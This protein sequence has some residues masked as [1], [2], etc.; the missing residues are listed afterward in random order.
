MQVKEWLYEEFPEFTEEVENVTVL[1]SPGDETGIHYYHDVEYVHMNE[2]SLHL[3]I[4][5]PFNRKKDESEILPCIAFVQGSAWMKQDVYRQLPLMGNLARRGYVVACIEYRHSEIAPFPAQAIDA[6]NAVR[7]LK[8]NAAKYGIDP[9]RVILGGDS[10]GGHTAMFA[11]IRHNDDTEEN[12]FPGISA[13]VKGIINLYGS[14]S[15]MAED[16]NPSTL[17][18]HL[19]DSPEGLEMGKVNLREHPE[20]CEELS[21]ECNISAD[22]EIA[23]VLIF[24]GT[25]DRTVNTKQSVT[26]YRKLKECGKDVQLYLIAGGDHGGAEYWTEQVLDIEEAFIKKCFA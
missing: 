15:V 17:N 20:L 16:G 8:K 12:L 3:Q 4:L 2:L 7:F 19:P 23:P 5:R 9:D 14:V 1:P 26:L 13:E 24:H 6:R 10:S 11:G 25:K 21:V 18:H 22:T